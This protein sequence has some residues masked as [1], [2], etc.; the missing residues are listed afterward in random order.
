M[1]RAIEEAVRVEQQEDTGGQANS[2]EVSAIKEEIN[3]KA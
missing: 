3:E 1:V 2:G